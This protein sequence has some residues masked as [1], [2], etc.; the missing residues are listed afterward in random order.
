MGSGSACTERPGTSRSWP[1]QRAEAPT[2][3]HLSDTCRA[4]AVSVQLP[5]AFTYGGSHAI[6]E[7]PGK[8]ARRTAGGAHLQR[9]E[10]AL[11]ACGRAAG[12]DAHGL[13]DRERA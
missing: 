7:S 6:E 11:P 1:S 10:G 12:P 2:E 5:Y 4:L 3:R 13:R 9:A 8:T